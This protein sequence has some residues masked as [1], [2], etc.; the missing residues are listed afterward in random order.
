M[1]DRLRSCSLEKSMD[2]G[3]LLIFVLTFI[4]HLIGPL[5]Y[6]V[7]IAGTRTRRIAISL[8][9]FNIL[10]LVSRTSNSFAAPLLAERVEQNIAR[11]LLVGAARDFRWLLLSAT[12][13]SIMGGVCIP[14]FQRLFARYVEPSLGTVRWFG[15]S[16]VHS[17][18]QRLSI[19]ASPF[20]FQSGETSRE[21]IVGHI[22]RGVS[23]SGI[24]SLWRSGRSASFQRCTRLI[25][26]RI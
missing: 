26:G 2:K 25:F 18:P 1:S 22:F 24:W 14:T 15:F 16:S 7:R 8:S 6:S 9:L 12:L 5:A 11:G 17:H 4:I 21:F 19:F 23:C 10:V 13:A 3:L 20:N